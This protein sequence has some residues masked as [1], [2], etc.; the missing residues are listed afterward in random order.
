MS[1]TPKILLQA[2]GVARAFGE[3]ARRRAVLE[4][5]DFHICRGEHVALL[6]RSGSGKS[7]LLNIIAGIDRAESGVITMNDADLARLREPARTLFRREHIGFVYQFFNLLPT[8]SVFDNIALP[9][10]LLRMPEKE[11]ARRVA[12]LLNAAGLDARGGDYPDQL[13]GGEQQRVAIAR[14]LAHR[15]A[16]VLAD[17]PTGNLDAAAGRRALEL[18]VSSAKDDA[19]ALLTATHSREV[20]RAADR[21]IIL[22]GGRITES[23]DKQEQLAW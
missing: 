22:D 2:R 8:L 16:L 14:A 21:V 18:L 13:S 17:E 6:G 3:G 5:A 1:E 23:G 15:P 11:I 12:E 9:L 19:P 10:Q 7:T 4:Q 20:A